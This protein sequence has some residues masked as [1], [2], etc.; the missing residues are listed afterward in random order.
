MK[1]FIRKD[2]YIAHGEYIDGKLIVKRGS[3]INPRFTS[4]IKGNSQVLQFRN[5]AEYVNSEW[6]VIEDCFFSSPSTAAQFVMGQ[7][8]NG[9]MSWK[10][11]TGESLG[12]Y[13]ELHGI[14]KRQH[15]KKDF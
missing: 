11:E 8:R 1:V 2:E 14:R 3:T 13:L 4:C 15:R 5:N 12:L 7:S 10:V 6:Q 9:F